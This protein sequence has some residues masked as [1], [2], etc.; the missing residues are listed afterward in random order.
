MWII[1]LYFGGYGGFG[2]ILGVPVLVFGVL[3]I[4]GGYKTKKDPPLTKSQQWKIALRLLVT[5]YT[6]LYLI[7]II[8]DSGK[9]DLLI[10]PGVILF[11]LLAIYLIGF[12]L[13][14]KWELIAGILFIIWYACLFL[15]VIGPIFFYIGPVKLFGLPVLIQG[16]LYLYYRFSFKAKQIQN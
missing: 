16:I 1:D 13:S 2:V 14:W 5:N 9:P 11:G 8:K 3:F 6:I 7:F 12:I 4:I 10:W 15:P